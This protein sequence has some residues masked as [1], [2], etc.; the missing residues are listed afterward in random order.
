MFGPGEDNSYFQLFADFTPLVPLVTIYWKRAFPYQPLS[1]LSVLLVLSMVFNLIS[2]FPQANNELLQILSNL[3]LLLELIFYGLVLHE[4]TR[5]RTLSLI[6]F[7]LLTIFLTISISYFSMK[8]F[9]TFA[10][11]AR[12]V[13]NLLLLI[14]SVTSITYLVYTETSLIINLPGFW[15][16]AGICF[17][18][19]MQL[20]VDSLGKIMPGITEKEIK[21]ALIFV[22]LAETIRQGCFTISAL[23][24]RSNTETRT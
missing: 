18:S 23:C 4:I 13:S 1:L 11:P 16:A 14:L 7:F 8:G 21:T 5:N 17:F 6:L 15:I 10:K 2:F 19:A 22:Y 20:L 12:L 24:F 3:F 9:Y